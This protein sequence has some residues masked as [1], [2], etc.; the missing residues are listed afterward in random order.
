M[1]KSEGNLS[2]AAKI[3][4]SGVIKNLSTSL[5][6]LL[7]RTVFIFYLN[8]D[9]LGINSAVNSIITILSLTE[10]GVGTSFI[11]ILYG[12][13][14]RNDYKEINSIMRYFKK[15][16]SYIG[17]LIFLIGVLLIPF[18]DK[19]ITAP[20]ET[21][22][23][24]LP[25]YLIFVC[26]TCISYLFSAYKR[27]LLMAD[28]KETI[29]N[30]VLTLYVIATNCLQMLVIC[31]TKNYILYLCCGLLTIM[32][33]NFVISMIAQKRYPFLSV[34]EAA[35]VGVETKNKLKESVSSILVV[36][37]GQAFYKASDNLV[38]SKFLGV[39]I[40]A[41]YD[42][43]NLI[44]YSLQQALS[45]I[46]TS[47]TAIIGHTAVNE[48]KEQ[49]YAKYKK[50][51]FVSV[52]LFGVCGVCY[53]N[54]IQ[55]FINWWIGNEYILDDW[56][57]IVFAMR[58]FVI[59]LNITLIVYKDA[60]GLFKYGRFLS[61]ITGVMNVILSI[62]LVN[63]MGILGVVLASLVCDVFIYYIVHPKAVIKI[64]M[65]MDLREY[66]KNY[67]AYWILF[68]GSLCISICLCNLIIIDLYLVKFFVNGII[69]FVCVFFL[70]YTA[71]RKTE[72]W[73]YMTSLI[74][75]K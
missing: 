41:M 66:Y 59:G 14:N 37:L 54:C 27:C 25:C 2:I 55:P 5:M 42:N 68:C 46:V 57:A 49:L 12:A 65:G 32:V 45:M 15:I 43:Y 51:E 10:L 21:Q 63:Q 18:L 8:K 20:N 34:K 28:K 9:L 31:I 74:I 22:K 44:L 13:L 7:T 6:S 64:G 30:N 3:F 48:T 58:F 29:V 26:Q 47:F 62:L 11:Y 53:I 67:L 24:V 70:F 71:K 69:S 56:F 19:L 39:G 75:K 40:L 16:Y 35:C 36:K 61:P 17:G 60:M 73:R 50:L 4:G 23:Y 38:I 1:D 52:F 72:E 33:Q